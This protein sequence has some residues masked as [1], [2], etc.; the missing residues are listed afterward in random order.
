MKKR[1]KIECAIA[2][3][4]ASFMIGYSSIAFMRILFYG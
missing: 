3:V 1:T 4:I 2:T